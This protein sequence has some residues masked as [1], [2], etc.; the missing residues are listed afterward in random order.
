MKVRRKEKVTLT[1]TYTSTHARARSSTHHHTYSHRRAHSF[2]HAPVAA[3]ARTHSHIQ[4]ALAGAPT[5]THP[6]THRALAAEHTPL[7]RQQSSGGCGRQR[8][9]IDLFTEWCT[10]PREVSCQEPAC[11]GASSLGPSCTHYIYSRQAYF[12]LGVYQLSH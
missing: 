7:T 1:H 10:P 6:N 2:T 8:I 9:P 11:T 12:Q 3:G 4:A 5:R